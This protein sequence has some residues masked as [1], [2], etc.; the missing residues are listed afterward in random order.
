MTNI[1]QFHNETKDYNSQ[2]LSS[3]SFQKNEKNNIFQR[4]DYLSNED[5]QFSP[6]R[7]FNFQNFSESKFNKTSNSKLN[8]NTSWEQD[9]HLKWESKSQAWKK[10][11]F[12]NG[13]NQSTSHEKLLRNSNAQ[14][15]PQNP[16][17]S[18]LSGKNS[19]DF[20]NV[21]PNI[22][23]NTYPIDKYTLPKEFKTEI[24]S[25]NS[26]KSFIQ[27]DHVKPEAVIPPANST[28]RNNIRFKT[29]QQLEINES[30]NISENSS[31]KSLFPLDD[32]Q[33]KI[34]NSPIPIETEKS[35]NESNCKISPKL[36]PNIN[37]STKKIEYKYQYLLSSKENKILNNEIKSF[38]NSL[39]SESDSSSSLS[40]TDEDYNSYLY[41]N[42]KS[43]NENQNVY[44]NIKAQRKVKEVLSNLKKNKSSKRKLKL[45][46]ENST[47]MFLNSITQPYFDKRRETATDF[48]ERLKNDER[49]A[50]PK[51]T[52]PKKLFTFLNEDNDKISNEN[53]SADQIFQ[54]LQ[55]EALSLRRKNKLLEL[56]ES[57]T[58]EKLKE[59]NNLFRQEQEKVKKLTNEIESLK[60][61]LKELEK[62]KNTTPLI[63]DSTPKTEVSKI[64]I[65][66][67][68]SSTVL[69]NID[70]ESTA[71]SKLSVNNFKEFTKEVNPTKLTHCIKEFLTT[72]QF[73][74]ETL[75]ILKTYFMIP[76]KEN[77]ILPEHI[78][79][80][81]FGQLPTLISI[82]SDFLEELERLFKQYF[83][84]DLL[85]L[86]RELSA[87]FISFEHRF[88]S[89]D[90]Y[91]CNFKLASSLI[92]SNT[93]PIVEKFLEEK[94]EELSRTKSRSITLSSYLVQPIQRLPRY[95]LLLQELSKYIINDEITKQKLA[96]AIACSDAI[97]LYCN[98]KQK[99]ADT[100]DE[101]LKALTQVE[102]QNEF[103]PNDTQLIFQSQEIR[104]KLN[105][106]SISCL[107]IAFERFFVIQ[108]LKKKQF[109]L[110]SL[111]DPN[112]LFK[113]DEKSYTF[114]FEEK[115]KS[116]SIYLLNN[117]DIFQKI[118]EYIH[119]QYNKKTNSSLKEVKSRNI[120]LL[121]QQNSSQ[122]I[123]TSNISEHEGVPKKVEEYYQ[124]LLSASLPNPFYVYQAS[125]SFI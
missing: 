14:N 73:Y 115:G 87:H 62:V 11:V 72:E 52:P 1:F 31:K 47:S 41:F 112:L 42:K 48:L 70:Q 117:S 37:P 121:R 5:M 78:L 99:E 75:N 64:S 2:N 68:P 55:D 12:F 26:N 83:N 123:S 25:P 71:S 98:S 39:S 95:R 19:N 34:W 102:L 111:T 85:M 33:K 74:V 120:E 79:K 114:Q 30:Q 63:N 81:A 97:A 46:K 21:Q 28:L 10:F 113:E 58:S 90:K 92:S 18:N 103:S 93:N 105:G 35:E 36:N 60:N 23:S 124:Q 66:Q 32:A 7:E 69:V 119:D 106:K 108:N 77:M 56:K 94:Y 15:N 86:A 100:K 88:K 82:N 57:R 3:T 110:I 80:L 4:I 8:Q 40:D 27:F 96:E 13:I 84:H 107:M 20:P 59:I 45:S 109:I 89:Y 24:N 91:I 122:L 116:Y 9:E 29:K 101:T 53:S 118:G 51:D 22:L 6:E 17:N 43:S 67:T 76:M 54:E 104:V 38:S 44:K 65:P 16:K 49:T 125:Q 61:K 50:V